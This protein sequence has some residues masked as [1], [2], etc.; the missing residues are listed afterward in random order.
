MCRE[1]SEATS[2]ALVL[3]GSLKDELRRHAYERCRHFFLYLFYYRALLAKLNAPPYSLGLKP[4]DLLYVNATHQID[5]GYR[6]T[7]TDYYAFDA[8]DA[9]I[10]DKSC[11]ACGRMDAAHFC[12]LGIDAGMRSK[13]AAIASKDKVVFCFYECLKTICGNTRLLPQRVN[14]GPDKCIDRFHG[15]LAT[16]IIKSGKPPLSSAHLKEYLQG[17]AKVFAEYSDT[18][19]KKGNLG[20]VACVEAYCE[21]YKHDGDDLWSMLYG[22]YISE[23]SISLYQLS[24]GD[25]ITL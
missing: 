16:A 8:K 24:A 15:E 11:A 25:F 17:A 18:Q 1:K 22:N 5:E 10:I 12:N 21:C 13:L 9:N 20:I 7:D 4:Q 19:Q 6:S 3:G 2:G 23:C 14:I